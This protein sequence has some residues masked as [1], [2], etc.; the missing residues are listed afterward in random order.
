ML[1]ILTSVHAKVA[2]RFHDGKEAAIG[3]LNVVTDREKFAH[4]EMRARLQSHVDSLLFLPSG[5]IRLLTFL[6]S[7]VIRY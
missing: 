1:G 6:P 7:G 4:L 2:I 3:R 5:V